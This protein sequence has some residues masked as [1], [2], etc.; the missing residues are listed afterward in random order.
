MLL[1][2]GGQEAGPLSVSLSGREI[3]TEPVWLDKRTSSK[4][5]NAWRAEVG[6]GDNASE[7]G[8]VLGKKES[9]P[10]PQFTA[11]FIPR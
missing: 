11:Y 7:L 3:K 6:P 2:V 10:M 1:V 4:A 8:I 5:W 9:G